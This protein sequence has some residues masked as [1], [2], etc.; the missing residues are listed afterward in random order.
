MKKRSTKILIAALILMLLIL[1]IVTAKTAK[2]TYDKNVASESFESPDFYSMQEFCG[3]NASEVMSALKSGKTEKIEEMMANPEGLSD[4]VAFADWKK[5][6]FKNAVSMGAGSLT[7]KPDEKG[8]IDISERFFVEIGEEKYVMFIETL[9]SRYGLQNDGVS[10]IG[11]TTYE[12]FDDL[13][14]AWNGEKDDNSALAGE[15]FWNSKN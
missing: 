14:Y 12:H 8:R 5:A 7:A 2:S 6:D 10:A 9:T 3:K 1:G 15:L 4:V 11:V 13:D